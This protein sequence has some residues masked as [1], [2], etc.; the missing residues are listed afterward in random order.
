MAFNI[1][2]VDD[3]LSMRSVIR[4]TIR[5]SGIEVENFYEAA[6]GL[7]ALN[8]LNAHWLDIILLDY[9]MPGMDGLELLCEIQKDD[10]LKTVPV[11]VMSVEGS[12]K[13]VHEFLEH[14][15]ADYIKKP[16]T[17]EETRDK[18]YKALGG[19]PY[20]EGQPAEG[21]DGLDF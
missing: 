5:A 4:K 8:I 9:N 1:L 19:M 6:N 12:Q 17:P 14:G 11:V 21:D 2:I 7:E 20:G 16:F 3:S 10:V 15:A 18:L 13:R